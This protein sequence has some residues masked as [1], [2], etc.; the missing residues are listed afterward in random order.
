MYGPPRVHTFWPLLKKT[1]TTSINY[2]P[3][4]EQHILENI[5]KARVYLEVHGRVQGSRGSRFVYET[6]YWLGC[7]P[8]EV[9]CRH[10]YSHGAGAT[11]GDDRRSRGFQKRRR[12]EMERMTTLT[13]AGRVLLDWCYRC[14]MCGM[15]GMADGVYGIWICSDVRGRKYIFHHA[16][17][18]RLS[19]R[20]SL[21]KSLTL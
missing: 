12:H 19:R 11:S 8:S 17:A 2:R 15:D 9:V 18:A 16:L 1:A 6:D 14:V 20:G 5:D 10:P 4:I 21:G 13:E 7:R 3:L